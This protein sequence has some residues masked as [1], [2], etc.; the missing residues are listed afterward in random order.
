MVI[1]LTFITV[2]LLLLFYTLFIDNI[3]EFFTLIP[4][5]SEEDGEIYPVVSKYRDREVAANN[6]GKMNIFCIKLIKKLKQVYL[7]NGDNN[8][9]T[10][11]Y[12]K[13]RN[14]V[15]IL[16]KRFNS[17]SFKENDTDDT[18]KTAFTTNK[19]EI[20]AL[21]LREKQSG[22]NKL[23][24]LDLVKFV[25]LHEL[26]H[27]IT[28]SYQHNAEFWINFK[29]LLDFCKKYDLYESIDYAKN[30]AIYCGL[31]VEFNPVFDSAIPSYFK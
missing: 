31:K 3:R 29:F 6:I 25:L 18:S 4:I 27:I 9:D 26:A 21:C 12:N 19:G 13:G 24:D 28:V 15:N 1:Y 11:E 23:H 5:K 10:P 30:N 14:A 7:D 2:L 17:E 8:I 22:Q 20:L 16:L